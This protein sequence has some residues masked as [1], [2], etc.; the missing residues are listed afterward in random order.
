MRM[1]KLFTLMASAVV[2]L[3]TAAFAL[4]APPFSTQV[5]NADFENDGNPFPNGTVIALQCC[6][7]NGG[8]GYYFNGGAAKSPDFSTANLYRVVTTE[9]GSFMLQNVVDETQY[10]GRSGNLVAMC[11]STDAQTFTAIVA[12]PTGWTTKPDDVKAGENTIRFI[13]SGGGFLNTNNT[14]AVPQYTTGTGGYSAWY[15]YTFTDEAVDKLLNAKPVDVTINYPAFGEFQPA[16]VIVQML[17]GATVNAASVPVPDYFTATDVEGEVGETESTLNVTGTWSFPFQ[18]DQVFRAD[19]RKG[20]A[21]GCNNWAVVNN[22]ISTRNNANSDDFSPENLFYFK[23]YG[24]NDA[25]R[26]IV[27]LH[28]T[29]L[30]EEEGYECSAGNNSKGAFSA[31]PTRWVVKKNSNGSNGISLQHPDNADAHAN[32][33]SGI[34]GVWAAAA[35]VN[36]GGSFIRFKALTDDDYATTVWEHH[37]R[38]FTLDATLMA[39]VKDNPTPDNVRAVFDI[40]EPMM[41]LTFKRNADDANPAI[42]K[43]PYLPSITEAPE[44]PGFTM[45]DSEFVVD[46]YATITYVL[47]EGTPFRLFNERTN[48]YVHVADGGLYQTPDADETADFIRIPAGEDGA[49][50]LYNPASDT[51]VGNIIATNQP[52]VAVAFG[53]TPV[54]Y[55][56]GKQEEPVYMDW[57][58]NRVNTEGGMNFFNDFQGNFVCGYTWNDAG[59]KWVIITDIENFETNWELRKQLVE[60][61]A[62]YTTA[63]DYLGEEDTENLA[64]FADNYDFGGD[65]NL[66]VSEENRAK[67][68]KMN[69]KVQEAAEKYI[70]SVMDSDDIYTIQ[71]ASDNRGAIIYDPENDCMTTTGAGEPADQNNENHLWGFVK[72]DGKH[73]L[74]NLGAQKFASAYTPRLEGSGTA[75]Y[76]WGVSEIPTAVTLTTEAFGKQEAFVNHR[77]TIEGGRNNAGNPAG[78]MII[79]SNNDPYKVPCSLGEGDI[80]DGTSFILTVAETSVIVE[81]MTAKAIEGLNKVNDLITKIGDVEDWTMAIEGVTVGHHTPEAVEA[82]TTAINA[83]KENAD[84]EAALYDALDAKNAFENAEKRQ[85]VNGHVYFIIDS[86]DYIHYTDG[87]EHLSAEAPQVDTAYSYWVATVDENG[88]VSFNHTHEG[89]KAPA[90]QLYYDSAVI[91]FAI[92]DVAAFLIQPTEELGKVALV[93]AEDNTPVDD[94]TYT[95]KFISEDAADAFTSH[96]AEIN[97]DTNKAGAIYDLQGRKLVAPVKGINIINGQKILVK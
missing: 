52:V 90:P 61:K 30:P 42:V 71:S 58:G 65:V 40:D 28:T 25:N 91:P 45:T 39:A 62:L 15:V 44:Y 87:V 21:Q 64:D 55:Y 92:N 96:I 85:V 81:E 37:E 29:G 88:V 26:L 69:A 95:I 1:K 10:V 77:F 46:N 47:N 83:A 79:N 63:L 43:L 8:A 51:F 76:V 22:Q 2:S 49:F 84:K 67:I 75:T 66:P 82:L 97:A 18:L 74:Y 35:S 7:T 38:T 16:P 14:A 72:V 94:K 80:K 54:K 53:Q 86:D 41:T 59:S 31:N 19:L 73:Y 6:D 9:D 32:D 48:K 50:V 56:A 36:D 33:I 78:M 60:S 20:S 4:P 70:E 34:L 13:A 27:T 68:E 17:P 11:A 12:T 93:D 24:F 3:T 23:A 5:V 89:D 57:I